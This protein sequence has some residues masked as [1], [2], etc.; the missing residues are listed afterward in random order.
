MGLVLPSRQLQNYSLEPVPLASLED[1]GEER[2]KGRSTC[3]TRD[4]SVDHFDNTCNM[5]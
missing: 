1:K 4:N 3:K 5:T 2:T